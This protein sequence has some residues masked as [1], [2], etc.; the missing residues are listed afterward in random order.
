MICNIST[1]NKELN[2][3]IQILNIP[4]PTSNNNIEV[5]IEM[6]VSHISKDSYREQDQDI[7]R[8]LDDES[9]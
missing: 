4:M 3:I 9:I 6:Q 2:I 8:S 1:I 5:E 7:L